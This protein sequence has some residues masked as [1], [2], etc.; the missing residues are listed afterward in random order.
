MRA[1]TSG[2]RWRERRRR[3]D[4]PVRLE[5]WI[6]HEAVRFDP[7]DPDSVVSATDQVIGSLGPAVELLGLGEALHGSEEILLLRNR[8]FE[9]LVERHGF[10]AVVI[11]TSSP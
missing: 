9:R 3:H 8:M 7:A 1:A 11:E 10:S 6:A 5:E 4:W 2:W